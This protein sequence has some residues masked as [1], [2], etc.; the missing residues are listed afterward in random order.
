[1]PSGSSAVRAAPISL[2]SSMAP[3][4]SMVTEAISGTC[5]PAAAMARLAPITAALA[6]SRSWHVSITIASTPPRSRPAALRW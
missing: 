6:C 3:V 4:V 1:M 5:T 2:P